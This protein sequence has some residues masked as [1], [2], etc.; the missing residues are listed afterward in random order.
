MQQQQQHE[1]Q[2]PPYN[3]NNNNPTQTA[4]VAGA[5]ENANQRIVDVDST[6]L[7]EWK[8]F[9]M[10]VTEK[11]ARNLLPPGEKYLTRDSVDL[12][13]TEYVAHLTVVPKTAQRI[14]PALQFYANQLEY[15]GQ[16]FTVSSKFVNEGIATQVH[17]YISS[18]VSSNTDPHKNLP[19]NMLTTK[20]HLRALDY[21]FTNNVSNW[22]S[23][24]MSWTLG[25]NSFIRCDTYLKLCF[26]NLC[27]NTTH[28]P[29]IGDHNLPMLTII[30]N[31]EQVKEGKIRRKKRITGNW[32]H[33]HYLMCGTGAVALSL[34]TKLYYDHNKLNFYKGRAENTKPSWWKLKLGFE[35]WKNTRIASTAYGT[36][37]DVCGINWGK[38]VHM[39]SAGIEHA[40]AVGE[41]DA[42]AVSTLSKHQKS[43][44]D[45]VY[46]TEL[47]P[48][49]LRVMAGFSTNEYQHKTNSNFY[50]VPRTLLHLPWSDQEVTKFIFPQ[51]D[52]WH[53]QFNSPEGDKS[54]AARNFLFGVLPFL[55]KV[56][57]Q[58]G[59]YWLKE[60]PKH[61]I[62]RLILEA[63]PENYE[64][65]CREM[66]EKIA[67]DEKNNNDVL[68]STLNEG[69]KAALLA[70]KDTVKNEM[71]QL[72]TKIEAVDDKLGR[73]ERNITL[74]NEVCQNRPTPTEIP[75]AVQVPPA[76][77]VQQTRRFISDALRNTPKVPVFPPQLP[78]SMVE[79][80]NEY[81]IMELSKWETCK[82]TAWP[83]RV[84]Q[85][86][87]RRKYIHNLMKGRAMALHHGTFEQRLIRCAGN[88]DTERENQGMSVFNFINYLKSID[89]TVKS[90]KR[91]TI[92]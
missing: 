41:L 6:Y 91:K 35:Q 1:R 79:M 74:L 21:I 25:N 62:S 70:V 75:R 76:P 61:E 18:A 31:A 68:A 26:P 38:I 28:G 47:F 33:K 37:L 82:M 20:E 5:R 92:T 72:Q 44:L 10:W 32:R 80:L 34:F 42:S 89:P 36:L 59:I 51:I 85:A 39:R 30:L 22:Q 65:W 83:S 49:V 53:L 15:V 88:L 81:K 9:Q 40:S 13:F 55:A 12:Y 17:S 69:A 77:P 57:V 14:R 29:R 87:C 67:V 90:R 71:Q 2:E 78:K 46:M 48:P 58:D 63:M 4:I 23:L 27:Y 73:I 54:E 66:R 19:C 7:R 84:K 45:K 50:H 16:D 56:V 3:N 60:Y 8:R 11:R 86:F 64:R 24:Y 52:I 43:N